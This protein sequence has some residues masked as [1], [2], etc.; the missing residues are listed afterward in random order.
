M[1]LQKV[2]YVC[3]T[4]T[5]TIAP[6]C[7]WQCSAGHEPWLAAADKVLFGRWCPK[8]A[9]QKNSE[10]C[11][12]KDAIQMAQAH[13]VSKGGQCLSTTYVNANEKLIWHCGCADHPSWEATYAKV[14][15][16]GQ[17]W[18]PMWPS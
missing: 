12:K 7:F 17:T 4:N 3:L 11:I 9:N 5:R 2:D 8:C 13:A 18:S 14:V 6:N 16:D 15:F 10:R 1:R